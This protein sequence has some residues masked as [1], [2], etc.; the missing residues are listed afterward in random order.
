KTKTVDEAITIN[1]TAPPPA[2]LGL[3][4]NNASI[5]GIALAPFQ[6]LL[7]S[8]CGFPVDVN[9]I[10][11]AA[12]LITTQVGGGDEVWF[13]PGDG[14][15][16]VTG[17]DAANVQQLGVIDSQHDKLLQTIPVSAGPLA[18]TGTALTSG[19]NPAAFSES[20]RVFV[21][22][23]VTAAIVAGTKP[24]DSLCTKFGVIGRGCIAVFAHAGDP[25]DEADK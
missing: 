9:A 6:H 12:T 20:N 4:A 18:P 24:D 10:T 2:G 11:G 13:N 23:P 25:D 22:T 1:C 14:R 21:D 15:F 16:Y 5:T 19:R 3:A 7:V 8:A 17:R